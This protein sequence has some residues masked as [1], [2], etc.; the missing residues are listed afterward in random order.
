MFF[1]IVF[2]FGFLKILTDG[3]G[4]S[5][6]SSLLNDLIGRRGI[7]VAGIF[8]MVLATAVFF[9]FHTN[10]SFASKI[11]LAMLGVFGFAHVASFVMGVDCGCIGAAQTSIPSLLSIGY[12]AFFAAGFL[13][14]ARGL[15]L[16]ATTTIYFTISKA[17][18]V[19]VTFFCMILAVSFAEQD[20]FRLI[21]IGR[22]P[23]NSVYVRGSSQSEKLTLLDPSC[24][25]CKE[26]IL[27]RELKTDMHSSRYWVYE[28]LSGKLNPISFECEES[29][30]LLVPVTLVVGEDG[31]VIETKNFFL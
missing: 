31:Q 7:F 21:D 20:S 18:A 10:A 13:I 23:K 17:I 16:S 5:A 22:L 15:S 19:V 12:V 14:A 3:N 9:S 27:D 11:L 30:F 8:E 2:S 29:T 26:F 24:K 25:K 4:N 28:H 6:P 1:G